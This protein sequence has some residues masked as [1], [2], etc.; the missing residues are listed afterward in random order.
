[1]QPGNTCEENGRVTVV[2]VRLG[3]SLESALRRFG[4]ATSGVVGET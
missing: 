1:M 3:E 4:K 2:Q